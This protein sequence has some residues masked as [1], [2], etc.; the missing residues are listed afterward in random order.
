[1]KH[2]R[3]YSAF[4][5]T[6]S[7]VCAQAGAQWLKYKTPGIPRTADGKP[8]L[9]AP[10]PRTADG[11]PD[12]SG[13]WGGGAS[14]GPV[15][16][17]ADLIQDVSDESIFRPAAEALFQKRLADLGRDWPSLH[18]LPI[19]P[20]S[21]LVGANRFRIV[22]SP[23]VVV[24]LFN[25]DFSGDDYRQIFL[26]GRE[27]PQDPNPTWHGYSVG[28]WNEDTLVV[29]SAGFNDRSWLDRSGHPHSERLH[30]TERFR[31]V[32]F[33]HLEYQI[34]FDDPETMTRP[35]TVQIV[36]NYQADTEM[37]ESVCENERDTAHMV[38]KA[39]DG[40]KV[41]AGV[42]AKYAGTYE[43]REGE[44]GVPRGPI[45]IALVNRQLYLGPLP[46]VPESETSFQEVGG[47]QFDFSLDTAGAIT[48]FKLTFGMGE[49]GFYVKR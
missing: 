12:L 33:G 31:R 24:M 23:T 26:D 7:I 44:S 48:G 41:S 11:K 28:H 42:L 5:L 21:V 36:K 46:L 4:A 13:F 10:V 25:N 39:V 27:L 30:T 19:G 29:E 6:L 38:G 18:C 9:S 32:D 37:L 8:N 22:Q 49:T 45:R 17:Q 15:A 43:L 34:T 1:M 2:R 35:L 3:S 14:P 47:N 40:I 16:Y 20:S